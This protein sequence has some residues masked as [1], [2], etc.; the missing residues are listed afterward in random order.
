[1]IIDRYLQQALAE[2]AAQATQLSRRSFVMKTVGGAVGLALL[3]LASEG[4]R[5]Q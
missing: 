1:M 4:V 2:A 3:P 5:A